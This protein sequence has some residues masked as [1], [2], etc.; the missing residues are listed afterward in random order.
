MRQILGSAGGGRSA[1]SQRPTQQ[2]RAKQQPTCDQDLGQE[3]RVRTLHLASTSG[4]R[5]GEDRKH[6][7]RSPAA[8]ALGQLMKI[9]MH[10]DAFH[11]DEL[12]AGS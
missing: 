6:G 4:R 2:S 5:E 1:A 3:R 7:H 8:R 10:V 9:L 12:A 11:A